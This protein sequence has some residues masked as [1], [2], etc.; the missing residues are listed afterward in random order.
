MFLPM[1]DLDNVREAMAISCKAQ[2]DYVYKRIQNEK[3]KECFAQYRHQFLC[4]EDILQPTFYAYTMDKHA[5]RALA[6][7]E[8]ICNQTRAN[9]LERFITGRSGDFI[10]E[11]L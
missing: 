6:M 9:A 3:V 7:I 11:K 5:K 4:A 1:N 10:F 2:F 8:D